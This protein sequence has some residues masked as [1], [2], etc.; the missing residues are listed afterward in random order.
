MIN[1]ISNAVKFT[2]T[3]TITCRAERRNGELVVS[4]I[5]T[6]MG[7]AP[8]DQPKVFERFKQV[9][10]TL[11]D[12]PKGT[13]LGLPICRE[14]VE[15]H[16]GRVWVESELGKGSTFSFSL[17]VCG[18]RPGVA[19]PPIELAALIRQLRDQVVVTTPR[20]SERTAAHPGR[21]RRPNIRELLM[22]EFTEAGYQVDVA[23]NGREALQVVRR[24]RPDLSCSTS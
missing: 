21:G 22:Q 9:G 13:G 8:A 24:D 5:D 4:V 19:P 7:I 14:I 15:H 16:G 18:D 12:K 3:G 2:D 10:D 23:G 1:L 20:T 11:T 17:P 6:G